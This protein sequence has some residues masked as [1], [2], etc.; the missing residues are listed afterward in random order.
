[1]ATQTI[2]H[3]MLARLIDAGTEC[4][5]RIVGQSGGWTVRVLYGAAE[6]TLTAQR[7]RQVRLFRKMDT[8]VAYLKDI[9]IVRFTVDA[10]NYDPDGAKLVRPDRAAAMKRAHEAAAFDAWFCT[11]VQAAIDDPRPSVSH[12]Q[13]KKRFAARKA[14]LRQA[15]K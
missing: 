13:A 11:Q 12:D 1:M 10:S 7:T 8:L 6:Q 15:V 9:G 14:A 5:A 2:D 3:N 4:G